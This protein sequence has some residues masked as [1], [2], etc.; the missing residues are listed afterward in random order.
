V[1]EVVDEAVA[2]WGKGRVG[3]R[4]SPYG[5]FNSMKDSN[6][7][8]L[9]SFVLS[10]L[11]RR[12]IAYAHLVEPRSSEAGSR[13]EN[14]EGTVDAAA[15]FR[16]SFEGC[17]ISAGGYDSERARNAVEGGHVDAVAFGRHFIANPDLPER[18]R[19]NL[20]FNR[21]DRSSFYGGTEKGY[22]DYP[23]LQK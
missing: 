13:D 11:S 4:L 20:A 12:Q 2:V 23:F 10:E 14:L 9:F 22:T 6:P 16:G 1:L 5:T 19:K 18:I 17:I 8:A 15:L 3:V 21:Y 7:K